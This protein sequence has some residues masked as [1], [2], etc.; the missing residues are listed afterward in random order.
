[1]YN[2]FSSCNNVTKE[3]INIINQTSTPMPFRCILDWDDGNGPGP[4]P[5][6]GGSDLT[7]LLMVNC[8][9]GWYN[10]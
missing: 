9:N 10:Y 2:V 8:L 5:P 3:E 4:E 6:V 1:M 7:L